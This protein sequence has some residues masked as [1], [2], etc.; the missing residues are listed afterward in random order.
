MPAAARTG[1]VDVLARRIR[2][3][4]TRRERA[5]CELSDDERARRIR[6]GGWNPWHT[7]GRRESSRQPEHCGAG[8]ARAAGRC[9]RTLSRTGQS[10]RTWDGCPAIGAVVP[11][12]HRRAARYGSEPVRLRG[13]ATP[14]T[15]SHS[16]TPAAVAGARPGVKTD[17]TLRSSERPAHVSIPRFTT[18]SGLSDW[19][20]AG[21]RRPM[22]CSLWTGIPATT[23]TWGN[24]FTI[25]NPSA[26][27]DLHFKP[28]AALPG[29][30]YRKHL[31]TKRFR[32]RA[33]R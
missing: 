12:S 6:P 9:G 29:T 17:L 11:V 22:N 27:A 4:G 24:R 26:A 2:P 20:N 7:T 16:T 10:A 13:T 19:A 30:R 14:P 1:G 18:D 15:R 21:C 3:Q 32:P 33:G 8:V 5:P 25:R 28:R 31:G 23:S